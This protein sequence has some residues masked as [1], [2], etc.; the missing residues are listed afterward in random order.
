MDR[1]ADYWI[2]RL[3]LRPHPEGGYYR[4]IYRSDETVPA[5][6]LPKRFNGPRTFS[7][8][9]YF[10]LEGNDFSALH[11]IQSDEIWHFYAGSP[12][13]IH[14]INHNGAYDRIV[15]GNNPDNNESFATVINAGCW[16]GATVNDSDAYALVGGTVAPGFEFEDFELANRADLIRSF[17]EHSAVI[18]RL[19]R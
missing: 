18:E 10:L 7:T 11:R 14:R 5:G 15:L 9:I 13:T 1:N 3:N 19:T 2:S 12:I 16:Y 17:P 6:V 4:E 8:A